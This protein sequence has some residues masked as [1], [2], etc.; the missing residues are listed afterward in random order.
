MSQDS[1]KTFLILFIRM[2][3]GFSASRDA[4]LPQDTE[5]PLKQQQ[6]GKNALREDIIVSKSWLRGGYSR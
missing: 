5:D 6:K 1:A 2:Q 4:G 3:Y